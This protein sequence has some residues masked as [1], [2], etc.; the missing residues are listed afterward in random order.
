MARQIDYIFKQ[1][2]GKVIL[3]GM[4]PIGQILNFDDRREFQN[5]GT[6]HI[7]SPIHVVDAPKIDENEDNPVKT[8]DETKP[9]RRFTESSIVKK[10]K[11]AGIGRPSTYVSTVQKLSDRKYVSKLLFLVSSS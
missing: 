5:R 8:T 9:P 2:W 3:S 10:M 1:L 4:H 11:S 7:H 6:E